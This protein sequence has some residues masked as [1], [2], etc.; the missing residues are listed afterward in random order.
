MTNHGKMMKM[1]NSEQYGMRINILIQLLELVNIM[2]YK[3]IV[4]C[5]LKVGN[6][7]IK[8]GVISIIDFTHSKILNRK[9]EL[10]KCEICVQTIEYAAPESYN[11]IYKKTSKIDM[12][13]IGCTYYRIITGDDI[14]E[15]DRGYKNVDLK[16]YMKTQYKHLGRQHNEEYIMGKLKNNVKDDIDRNLIR[17]MLTEDPKDRPCANDVLQLLCYG[18]IYEQ[19]F[20]CKSLSKIME[21]KEK[22]EKRITKIFM[23]NGYE[24]PKKIAKK[25]LQNI[26][27]IMTYADMEEY[28]IDVTMD[29]YMMTLEDLTKNNV[30]M[31][32][33]FL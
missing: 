13:G 5:D 2:E 22:I 6:F 4:H 18:D 19:K 15:S 20:V 31:E 11:K 27:E 28:Y 1:I 29:E 8:N 10:P 17:M 3:N 21:N 7:L 9:K 32:E 16:T 25:I 33:Y 14:F 12:W 24:E 23:D 26:Y 30:E